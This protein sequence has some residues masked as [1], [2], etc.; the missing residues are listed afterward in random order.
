MAHTT[1]DDKR[2]R[3]PSVGIVGAGIAGLTAALRLAE[4]GFEV[5]VYERNAYAGGLLSAHTHGDGHYHEH[6]YHMFLNWYNNFW[7][8]VEDI[9]LRRDE[10]FEP[11]EM[12][13]YLR[14]GTTSIAERSH[15]LY[16]PGSPTHILDNMLS[17]VAPPPDMF[18]SAYSLIDL[19]TQQFRPGRLLDQYSVNSFM[20]SR[21]YAS[22]HSALLHEYTLAKAFAVPSYLTSASSY[23]SF[24]KYGLPH[25]D[26]LLWT[27]RSN[28]EHGLIDPLCARLRAL[29]VDIRLASPVK[30]LAQLFDVYQEGDRITCDAYIQLALGDPMVDSRSA[31]P[32]PECFVGQ[33]HPS[34]EGVIPLKTA[35]QPSWARAARPKPPALRHD[36]VIL[37]VPHGVLPKFLAPD[38]VAARYG[39]DAV[40][41]EVVARS[42]RAV[43]A[44]RLPRVAKLKSEPMAALDVHFTRKLPGIPRE[45]VVLMDSPYGLT[46]IDNSQAWDDGG[47]TALNVMLTD[48]KA[49]ANLEPVDVVTTTLAELSEYIDFDRDDVDWNR[50]HLQTNIGDKLFINEVGSEAYRPGPTATEVPQLFLAGDFCRTPI[51][52]VTVE[53]AVVSGLQAVNALQRQA[54]H[55]GW[56][57][58]RDPAAR[59]VDIVVP[60]AY[61]DAQLMG[62]KLLLAPHAYAAKAWSWLNEQVPAPVD[63]R[64]WDAMEAWSRLVVA[65]WAIAASGWR[66]GWDAWLSAAGLGRR[67]R[68]QE[69][70]A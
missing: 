5:T 37:A 57:G 58:D 60:D 27:L 3:M 43:S 28:A 31:A 41:A 68:R 64:P 61:P 48:F 22:E 16:S 66:M 45:H 11:R 15:G 14:R 25:P 17:G 19:L 24:I 21:P 10:H 32:P 70:S 2:T 12:V 63:A 30:S 49:L 38:S 39:L 47:P 20:Q 52:V 6:C 35:D 42:P 55:D 23:K 54:V 56:L 40:I 50:I 33:G 69:D 36:Y 8:L 18:L 1:A 59:P 46:F 9:G 65:P 67:D 51:D 29:G 34:W 44:L 13:R 4:R 7:Q 26:P 62:L 53:A